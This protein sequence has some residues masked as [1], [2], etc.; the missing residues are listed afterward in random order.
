[1][2]NKVLRLTGAALIWILGSIF[3]FSIPWLENIHIIILIVTFVLAVVIVVI[4]DEVNHAKDNKVG[5][6]VA[7]E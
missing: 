1:M 3:Y 2:N 5:E 7:N 4:G 6:G